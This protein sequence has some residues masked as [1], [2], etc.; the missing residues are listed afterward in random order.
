MKP[1]SERKSSLRKYA[2]N[3]VLIGSTGA[4]KTSVGFQLAKFL[5][6]GVFDIDERIE[7]RYQ[8]D[9]ATIFREKGEDGFRQCESSVIQDLA[10]IR[11]HIIIAGGGAIESEENWALLKALGPTVWLA[12]P[13]SEVARRLIA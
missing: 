5:G 13:L 2:Q 8:K 6:Y 10:G 11:N 7:I 3:I 9:I 12:T 4:G 1:T